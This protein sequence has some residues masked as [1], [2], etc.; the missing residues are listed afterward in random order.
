[1]MAALTERLRNVA[2]RAPAFK[3]PSTSKSG[4]MSLPLFQR[5]LVSTEMPGN[6]RSTCQ[7]AVSVR[8]NSPSSVRINT[9]VVRK[10]NP[11]TRLSRLPACLR[12]RESKLFGC[13]QSGEQALGADAEVFCSLGVFCLLGFFHAFLQSRYFH[14]RD[15][16]NAVQPR[17]TLHV[18]C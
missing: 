8:A 14:A 9:L 6:W 10:G 1:M 16:K 13:V 7:H 3:G 2:A 4:T 15:R 12:I 5:S 18:L 17:D 11:L